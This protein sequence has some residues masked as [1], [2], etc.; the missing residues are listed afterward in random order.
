[1]SQTSLLAIS[2]KKFTVRMSHSYQSC[3]KKV[4]ESIVLRCGNTHQLNAITELSC[5]I[6]EIFIFNFLKIECKMSSLRYTIINE[7]LSLCVRF[8]IT[9][10]NRRAWLLVS[11]RA[12]PQFPSSHRRTST[13]RR[14]S[15]W[16]S[17]S[18]GFFPCQR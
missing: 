6:S 14:D 16:L 13:A 12:V 3:G 11:S 8:V 4:H 5:A 18:P 15:R 7:K 17:Q 2:K 1:M 9:A 10:T